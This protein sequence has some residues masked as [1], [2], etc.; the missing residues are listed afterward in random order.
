MSQC[1]F[2]LSWGRATFL[3]LAAT[4]LILS[5]SGGGTEE[6]R[7]GEFDP[8]A[9]LTYMDIAILTSLD[10]GHPTNDDSFSQTPL[11]T[12][13]DRLIGMSP[14]GDPKPGLATEWS[15]SP[16]LT[17]VRLKLRR[18]VKF[19][20]GTVFDAKAVKANLGR[21]QRLGENTSATVKAAVKLITSVEVIDDS[22][23]SITTSQPDGGFPYRLAGQAGMMVSP[24]AFSN[25]EGPNAKAVGTGPYKLAEFRPNDTA[26]LA[27]F[28]GHWD[29]QAFKRPARFVIRSVPDAQARLNAVISGEA[30]VALIEPAQIATAQQARLAV[31]R[32]PKLSFW[33]FYTNISGPMADVRV[34]L[35]IS[36]A[37]DR[38]AISNKLTFGTGEPTAQLF[39]KGYSLWLS[40]LENAY[41]RDVARAKRLLTEAGYPNGLDLE[42]IVV[43]FPEQQQMSQALQAQLAEAGI[44]LK[45]KLIDVSQFG[46]FLKGEGN[47]MTAR[48]G[49]RADP[50]QTLELLTAAEGTY[51]PGGTAGPELDR[52]LVEARGFPAG[53]E[54]RTRAL[55]A[56]EREVVEKM[57]VIPIVTR[58]NVYAYRTGCISGLHKWVA[59]GSD[60]WG[61]VT[62]SPKCGK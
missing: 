32:N 39:P 12:L 1:S 3:V 54:E 10:P 59:T 36:Y 4:A 23:V 49:G 37:I 22:T 42:L 18:G 11:L 24:A 21:L 25:V 55:R 40:D 9:T 60:Y 46:I 7:A 27:R 5:A 17:K 43:T 45:F 19:H 26:V 50:L 34:R 28:D 16:D 41:Q 48:W 52:L 61:D 30:T 2:I 29:K 62:V 51:T 6:K 58:V 8:N 47:L 53:S 14:D 33:L 31:Q 38:K 56:V 57:A 13:Y 44:R 15:F 35:A 20:D